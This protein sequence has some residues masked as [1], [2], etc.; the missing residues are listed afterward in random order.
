MD[1]QNLDFSEQ[2]FDLVVANLILSVVPDANRCMGEIFRV[3]KCEGTIMI[4]DKFEPDNGKRYISKILLCPLVSIL[5][6]DIGRNLQRIIQPHK[7]K[8]QIQQDTPVLFNGMYR[9]IVL[10]KVK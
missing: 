3:T 5:G 2:T 7:E 4:F 10:K 8:L 1:A 6:T 9:K